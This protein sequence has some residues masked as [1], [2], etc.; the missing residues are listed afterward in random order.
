MAIES[1]RDPDMM[2][3][4]VSI[5]NDGSVGE[6]LSDLNAALDCI[7][8]SLEDSDLFYRSIDLSGKW[9]LGD[10]GFEP[11]GEDNLVAWANFVKN[12]DV[13]PGIERW[14]ARQE[15]LLVDVGEFDM[16][17]ES[18]ET[19]L[20]EPAISSLAMKHRSFVPLYN[21]FLDLWDLNHG[22]YQPGVIAFLV[23]IHGKCPEIEDMLLNMVLKHGGDGD[24]IEYNTRPF[25]EEIYGDFPESDL[26]RR[27]VTEMHANCGKLKDSSGKRYIFNYTP[28][29]P[30]LGAK[31]DAILAELDAGV[32]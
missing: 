4:V 14:L 18:E 32:A 9:R 19:Q 27:M 23:K 1:I 29:W 25:L 7:V 13:L 17:Y 21:R 12:E 2:A 31:A 15:K 26:F 16:I 10:D 6:T 11:M 30:E 3:L 28:S 8:D 22:V 5:Q 20:G 24:L